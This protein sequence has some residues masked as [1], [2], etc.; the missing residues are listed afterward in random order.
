[1]CPRSQHNGK[2]ESFLYRGGLVSSAFRLLR[3]VDLMWDVTRR[4]LASLRDRHLGLPMMGSGGCGGPI[5]RR[6]LAVRL[7][8]GIRTRN[9]LASSIVPAGTSLHRSAEFR[10]SPV[11]F[12]LCTT[13]C[14]IPGYVA[15]ASSLVQRN[16]VPST[17]MRCMMTASRRATATIARFIPR[18]RAIF[19]PQSSGPGPPRITSR[20]SCRLRISRCPPSGRSRPTAAGAA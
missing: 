11:V 3:P 1:M 12:L 9:G 15:A 8:A 14:E 5:C 16:S 6:V 17:H 2:F 13:R 4:V 10:F 20:A 7:T 18:C 19:R